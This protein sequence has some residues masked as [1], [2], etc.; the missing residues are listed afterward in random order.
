VFDPDRLPELSQG[1]NWLVF[2]LLAEGDLR[3]LQK[4]N[5]HFSDDLLS[6]LLNEP[7]PGHGVFWSSVSETPYPIP[8]RAL[9]FEKSFQPADPLYARPAADCYASRL[10]SRL[11]SARD[12]QFQ[13]AV[14]AS[15]GVR[16]G[17][18]QH[19]LADCL[20]GTLGQDHQ[21][22]FDWVHQHGLVKRALNEILGSDGWRSG[23]R[24]G[25]Q[26]ILATTAARPGAA[27][28]R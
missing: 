28:K 23:T 20:P 27:G 19:M 9:L 11:R 14:R 13:A 2:H 10:R 16:W 21:E 18:V 15:R 22:R 24:D 8:V 6:S 3:A 1:D 7:L 4:A 12:E 17:F 26:W 5:A 25:S